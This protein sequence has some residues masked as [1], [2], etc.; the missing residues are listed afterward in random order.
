MVV[1]DGSWNGRLLT[2]ATGQI[3]I[4]QLQHTTWTFQRPGG[5]PV[6][7]QSAQVVADGP[8]DCQV[9]ADCG[10]VTVVVHA[11][12]AGDAVISASREKCGELV[13]CDARAGTFRLRVHVR[14]FPQPA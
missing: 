6:L 11:A 1:V 2:V 8:L 3:V 10:T 13:R 7:R 14:S 9:F 5:G 4:V 12:H